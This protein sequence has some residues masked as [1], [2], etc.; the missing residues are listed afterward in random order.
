MTGPNFSHPL[1]KAKSAKLVLE[2][3]LKRK[4]KFE[5]SEHYKS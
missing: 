4:I 1:L 5:L 3:V 2:I